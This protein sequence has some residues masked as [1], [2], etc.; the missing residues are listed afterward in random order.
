MTQKKVLII[1][2][3]FGGV[4]AAQSLWKKEKGNVSICVVDPE[5]FMEYRAALYRTVTG[6]NPL[7]V[8]LPF[9]ELFDGMDIVA[10]RDRIV[11]ID[12]NQKK[13]KGE[14]GSTYAFDYVIL[15]TGGRPTTFGIQG[16]EEH[17]FSINRWNDALRLKRH[18]HSTFCQSKIAPNT[19]KG[20]LL[21]FVI[22]GGGATGVELAGELAD[23]GKKLAK[24]HEV[25]ASLIT[26]DLIEALPRL[27]ANLPEH[28][29]YKA[30]KRLESLGVKVYLNRTVQ[31][32]DAHSLSLSGMNIQTETV[33]WTAGVQ[34]S[35]LL[36]AIPGITLDKKGRAI[37]NEFLQID[38]K[39]YAYTIGDAASTKFSGMAQTALSDGAYVADTISHD[40]KKTQPNPYK[41]SC[42]D[43]AIPVGPYY[44]IV[45]FK[46]L[47]FTGV[48]GWLMRRVA[49]AKALF[50]LLPL[51]YAIR[52]F[53][54]GPVPT[55]SCEVCRGR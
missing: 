27:L 2:G 54:T 26:I 10:V 16:V 14:T 20:P 55:E 29:S 25:H 35:S 49:D 32:E 45:L 9:R 7:E 5:S 6:R 38:G 15:A 53:V 34:G 31:K 11:S 40:L 1:G 43:Y 50:F 42:P 18:I 36:Q 28:L 52:T 37:V 30:Q 46:G 19:L 23:Y 21:H 8:C 24:K 47:A 33:V 41:Q 17:A 51:R 39:K 4:S 48:I 13:A 22:V 44:A 12:L 3:G